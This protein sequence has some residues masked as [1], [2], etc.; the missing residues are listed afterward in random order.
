MTACSTACAKTSYTSLVSDSGLELGT[1]VLLQLN[2]F[3][4]H[5]FIK[6]LPA[7]LTL[8]QI[9]RA[10]YRILANLILLQDHLL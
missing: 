3:Q 1:F 7:R 4:D 10:L 2:A 8:P 6:A 9:E 5:N